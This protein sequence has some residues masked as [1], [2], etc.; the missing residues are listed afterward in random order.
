M[1]LPPLRKINHK[2]DNITG[3]SWIAPNRPSGDRFKHEITD[4]INSEGI[5]GRVSR[6]EDDTNAV[7]MFTQPKR[8]RPK[9][10]RF[11]LDCKPRKAVTLRNHTPLHNIDEAIEFIA[12][13]P[14]WSKIDLTDGYHNIRIDP[15]SEKHTNFLCHMGHYYNG[16][17][18]FVIIASIFTS[19]LLVKQQAV[20]RMWLT[21]QCTDLTY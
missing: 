4:T 17:S 21:S 7:V 5:S 12:G 19:W 10:P 11:L 6:A 2:I 18:P 16:I 13:R 15:E 20:R 3:S 8:D 1:E 9:E 14:L